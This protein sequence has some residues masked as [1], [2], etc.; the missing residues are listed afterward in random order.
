MRADLRP[1]SKAAPLQFRV[2]AN[3]PGPAKIEPGASMR[4]YIDL[5]ARRPCPGSGAE[6]DQYL[7]DQTPT[8]TDRLKKSNQG[9]AYGSDCERRIFG[10]CSCC[11]CNCRASISQ[12]FVLDLPFPT[13]G[14]L[15]V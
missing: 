6:L 13:K 15:P 14:T 5:P 2:F 3:S 8:E 10:A 11:P 12:Q 1:N 4:R 7:R 9:M